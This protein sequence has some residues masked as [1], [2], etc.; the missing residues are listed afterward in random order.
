MRDRPL[1]AVEDEIPSLAVCQRDTAET[2]V[3]DRR[4]GSEVTA[5][6]KVG[7]DRRKDPASGVHRLESESRA[8]IANR[9]G[10]TPDVRTAHL[11]A[12]PADHRLDVLVGRSANANPGLD[13]EPV[14][15]E[16]SLKAEGVPGSTVD[17]AGG[18]KVTPLLEGSDGPECV[19][20]VAVQLVGGSQAPLDHGHLDTGPG[21]PEDDASTGHRHLI[22]HVGFAVGCAHRQRE[23]P[24]QRH[25]QTERGNGG[26]QAQG[27]GRDSLHAH[28]IGHCACEVE[29]RGTLSRVTWTFADSDAPLIASVVDPH[30]D[31][32]LAAGSAPGMAYAVLAGGTVIHFKGIGA[33]GLPAAPA[34]DADTVFRIASMTKSFTAATVLSLRDGGQLSLD[35]PVVDLVP[36]LAAGGRR[37]QQ[38]TVRHLLTMGGGLLT[39]DPW[40]DRQQDLSVADFRQL[41]ARGVSPLWSPGVRFEYSNLGYALLGLVIEAVTG[42]A[43]SEVVQSQ[44][45]GPLGMTSSGYT[46][47]SDG[48]WR[49]GGNSGAGATCAESL[50]GSRNLSLAPARSRRW[51]AC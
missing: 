42:Q 23:R 26:D 19:G 49:W 40:G 33:R 16:R 34:P 24:G 6:M 37:A 13:G 47:D 29:Q 3:E 32:S 41:V 14:H 4:G 38:I 20:P 15:A 9:A 31:R 28:I 2:G 46:V 36:E 8:V 22:G 39:D 30:F 25:Q 7:V 43:Y 18:P 5:L 50:A 51:A 17:L 45:L 1:G 35:A 11:L 10:P 21:T 48:D 12:G 27:P 44:V